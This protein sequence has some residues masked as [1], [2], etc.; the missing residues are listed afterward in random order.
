MPKGKKKPIAKFMSTMLV[1]HDSEGYPIAFETVDDIGD[2]FEDCTVGVYELR[3]LAKF[4]VERHI[5]GRPSS[6]TK[7]SK[8]RG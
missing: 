4:R 6:L 7:K 5:E 3:Q 2:E 8:R 1:I